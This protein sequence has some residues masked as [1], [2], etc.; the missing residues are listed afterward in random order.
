MLNPQGIS[1]FLQEFVSKPSG[2]WNKFHS[3][4]VYNSRHE[5]VKDLRT[6]SIGEAVC[7]PDRGQAAFRAI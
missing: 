5:S 6:G 1:N 2:F 3:Q 4:K 7:G